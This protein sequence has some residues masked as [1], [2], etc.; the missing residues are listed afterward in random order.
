MSKINPAESVTQNLARMSEGN[1]GALSVL[2]KM[3]QRKSGLFDILLLDDM[4]I[5][6]PSVWI[7]YKDW[8]RQDL[9]VFVKGLKDND[10][11]LID[12]ITSNG[13]TARRRSP[14]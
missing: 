2:V 7:G 4:Q 6:G 9:E 10:K 1:P 13:G 3:L 12:C 8:A 5:Y 11:S 14:T